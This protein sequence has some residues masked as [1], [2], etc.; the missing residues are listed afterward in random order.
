MPPSTVLHADY[1]REQLNR[2]WLAIRKGDTVL[3]YFLVAGEPRRKDGR[4]TLDAQRALS[5]TSA[6]DG[7]GFAFIGSESLDQATV[8]R[9]QAAPFGSRASRMRC[10][11]LLADPEE[12]LF[13]KVFTRKGTFWHRAGG[14]DLVFR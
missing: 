8:M 13:W 4:Y 2:K 3:P 7:G 6:T 5:A 14:G 1:S 11:F 9:I 12:A 10:D